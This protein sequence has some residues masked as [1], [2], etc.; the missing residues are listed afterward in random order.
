MVMVGSDRSLQIYLKRNPTCQ[1]RLV[2][3]GYE[4]PRPGIFFDTPFGRVGGVICFDS[5]A[6]ETFERFK[7]SGV[8]MV[9]I[10]VL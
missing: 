4:E 1:E 6:R 2:W 3:K 7:Q 8:D 9:I 10:V 5:F